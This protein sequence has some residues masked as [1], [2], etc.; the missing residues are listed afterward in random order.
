L[1][2]GHK[3]VNEHR[4]VST[5]YQISANLKNRIR[6]QIEDKTTQMETISKAKLS[7]IFIKKGLQT[8]LRYD[9]SLENI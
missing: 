8:N 1:L 2:Q 7:G 9:T 6:Q 5:D 3:R 4:H